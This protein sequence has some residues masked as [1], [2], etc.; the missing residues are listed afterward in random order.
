MRHTHFMVQAYDGEQGVG[1]EK[2]LDGLVTLDL[3]TRE[4]NDAIARAKE[5]ARGRT[6]YKVVSIF[7]HDPDLELATQ[8]SE[9]IIQQLKDGELSIDTIQVEEDTGIIKNFPSEVTEG[10]HAKNNL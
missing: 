9:P 1:I 4:E 10:S 8:V 3:I 7:E 2:T 6:W 5:L